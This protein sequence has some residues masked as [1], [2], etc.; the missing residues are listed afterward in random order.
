MKVQLYMCFACVLSEVVYSLINRHNCTYVCM[1]RCI[2]MYT[3]QRP[4]QT[5]EHVYMTDSLTE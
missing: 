3:Y 2:Y 5:H 4:K 1:Y